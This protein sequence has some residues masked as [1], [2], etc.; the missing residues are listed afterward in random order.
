MK[1]LQSIQ[2]VLES[3]GFRLRGQDAVLGLNFLTQFGRAPALE[4]TKF[5]LSGGP[6]YN[7]W[8]RFR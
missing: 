8:L 5:V 7:Y 3:T 2:A 1:N 4:I 6:H